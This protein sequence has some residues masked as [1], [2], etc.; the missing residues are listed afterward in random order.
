[1]LEDKLEALNQATL[2]TQDELMTI[3]NKLSTT[4]LDNIIDN[5]SEAYEKLRGKT[6]D[7][8]QITK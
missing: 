5:L 6:N 7:K 4:A 3:N 1:M 8:R 2:L